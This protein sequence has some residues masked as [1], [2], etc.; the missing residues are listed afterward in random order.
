MHVRAHMHTCA[1]AHIDTTGHTLSDP[2]EEEFSKEAA[3]TLTKHL[4][5]CQIGLARWFQWVERLAIKPGDLSSISR[6]HM[7]A[8]T[9]VTQFPRDLMT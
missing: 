2:E 9:I 5:G 7:V 8:H 6:T 3:A 1:H 4:L